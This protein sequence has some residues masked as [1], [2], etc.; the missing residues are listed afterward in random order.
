LN[1]AEKRSQLEMLR[2]AKGFAL[3]ALGRYEDAL[4][5]FESARRISGNGKIAC[6]GKGLVF[7]HLGE[8][9]KALKAFDTILISD[10]GNTQAS[11]MKA[12]ALVRLGEFEKALSA[13]ERFA[14][15][16][17]SDLPACLLGFAC[18]RLENFEKAL[19]AYRKAIELNPKNF[20]ARNGL[21]ELYFKLGNSRGALKELEASIAE[22][23]EDAFSRCLKGRI[24]LEEQAC[25]DA[26][27]SFRRALA[28]NTE[29]QKL[30]LWDTYARYM[31]AEA[32]FDEGSARFR[33]ML[34]A[35]AGKL[36]KAAICQRPGDNELKAYSLYF[37]GLF[38]CRARYF[39]KAAGNLEECLKLKNLGEVKKPASMLLKNIRT[40]PLKPAWWE[41]WL[42]GD[43]Y[44]LPKK[45]GLGVIFLL[46]SGLLLSHPAAS[47]LP[48]MSW[49]ASII[50]QLFSSAGTG[51]V[52]WALYGKEYSVLLLFLFSILFLPR[53]RFGKPENGEFELESL[54]PPPLDFDIPSSVIEEFTER[55]EKSL[56]S[57]EPMEE[58]IQ[59]LGSF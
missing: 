28:L 53:F 24:E 10:P 46:I 8:W 56:F 49:P 32:S 9:E 14:M 57:P 21:A 39:Q 34:L 19:R 4:K 36:E 23:P 5:A 43:T 33:Y 45:A 6:F 42:D 16:E 59:K 2:N 3:D 40:G 17:G 48:L 11:V 31:Y 58:S 55:L 20:Y 54:T 35:A 47:T 25:E 50:T 29:D 38:Y 1:S 41:W 22:F 18:S 30:L 13:L 15:N 44:S 26:L 37:L 12:F 7:A 27:E 52:S 51:H